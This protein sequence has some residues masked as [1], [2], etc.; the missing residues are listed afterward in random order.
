MRSKGYIQMEFE[1]K[2]ISGIFGELATFGGVCQNNYFLQKRATDTC[3]R[4]LDGMSVYCYFV[5][6]TGAKCVPAHMLLWG[7]RVS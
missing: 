6:E 7:G 1:R 2:A 4:E 5:P 3:A